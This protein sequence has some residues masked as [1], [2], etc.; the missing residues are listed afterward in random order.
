MFEN[1]ERV[2]SMAAPTT[3][4]D[5][6]LI[7]ESVLLPFLLPVVARNIGELEADSGKDALL[8]RLYLAVAQRLRDDIEGD[9]RLIRR[10]LKEQDIRVWEDD[11]RSREEGARYYRYR[12]RA[13]K[14]ASESCVRSLRQKL[15]H[16]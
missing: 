14:T 1:R 11:K 12:C 2:S 3:N 4:E 8:C 6:T 13:M 16:D 7:R 9:V 10:T 5:L 15:A